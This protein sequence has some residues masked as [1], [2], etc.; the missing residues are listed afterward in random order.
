MWRI[1]SVVV[2]VLSGISVAHGQASKSPISSQGIGDIHDLSLMNHEGMGGL[3]VS[4]SSLWYLNNINPA[5]LP[6]N[7]LTVFQAGFASESRSVFTADN[8]STN[9]GGNLSYL[10]TAFPIKRNVWTSAIGLFPYSTVEYD[11]TQSS[12]IP[13]TDNRAVVNNRG[14]GGLNQFYWSNGFRINKN[15]SFGVKA[16]Y[17]FS[18]I[19]RENTVYPQDT[20]N[21][22][23]A[24]QSNL[25]DKLSVSDIRFSFGGVFKIDSVFNNRTNFN[26]GVVYE[27]GSNVNSY[28][29]LE[30]EK[31]TLAGVSFEDTVINDVQGNIYLPASLKVGVSLSRYNRWLVG[32][33]VKRQT[34]SDFENFDGEND[35][36]EDMMKIILGGE[37]IPDIASVSSYFKRISYRAGFIY[38]ELPF[39]INGNQVNEIGIN[40]GLSLPLGRFSSIDMAFGY[41]RR[42]N[43]AETTIEEEVLRFGLGVTFNDQWF[44]R[45]KYD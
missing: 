28:Q 7:N 21:V 32:V 43:I 31:R 45:R 38:T 42:G 16:S 5:L 39:V 33:D 11:F 30:L 8:S 40:F 20:S 9:V 44:I 34:W 22:T 26:V 2:I 25:V 41:G 14:S 3:G 35:G 15:F 10:A 27:L 19:T 4:A 18:S 12:V 24:F 29:F 6:D 23:V 17:L 13:G 1:L 37:Y 36:L